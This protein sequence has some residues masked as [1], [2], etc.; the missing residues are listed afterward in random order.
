MDNKTLL[1]NLGIGLL[2][3]LISG[4]LS[5]WIITKYYRIKDREQWLEAETHRL[6]QPT[7]KILFKLDQ[8]S[9]KLKAESDTSQYVIDLKEF[10]NE[11]PILSKLMK[12]KLKDWCFDVIED[13]YKTINNLKDYLSQEEISSDTIDEFSKNI[14]SNMFYVLCV[15]IKNLDE[16]PRIKL[17]I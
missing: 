8:L 10:L 16:D 13:Y 4:L 15:P 9:I 5:G 6:L 1:I 11:I 14:N 12:E 7:R 2:T 3:G 17:K